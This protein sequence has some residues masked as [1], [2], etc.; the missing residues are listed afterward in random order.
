MTRKY[1]RMCWVRIGRNPG[2]RSS[3]SIRDACRKRRT[4]CSVRTLCLFNIFKADSLG[5]TCAKLIKFDLSII[6][7]KDVVGRCL[8]QPLS[9]GR[10]VPITQ[11]SI[12]GDLVAK[13]EFDAIVR[14]WRSCSTLSVY[15][16]LRRVIKR[17]L[18]RVVGDREIY[19]DYNQL[20]LNEQYDKQPCLGML[21]DIT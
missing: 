18:H 15:A 10:S 8:L 14:L 11:S 7:E 13:V 3:R 21:T 4:L 6:G 20:E 1:F 5:G 16:L 12:A 17:R 9:I 2:W 19:T